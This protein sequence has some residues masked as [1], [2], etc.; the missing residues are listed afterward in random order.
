[1]FPTVDF[2]AAYT[3]TITNMLDHVQNP[4]FSAGSPSPP[5]GAGLHPE[6]GLP[7]LAEAKTCIAGAIQRQRPAC[8]ALAFREGDDSKEHQFSET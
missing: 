5:P 3:V 6:V 4:G 1:M 8:P 7:R 2:T